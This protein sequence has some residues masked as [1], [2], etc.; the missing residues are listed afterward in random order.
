[1]NSDNQQV[2][3]CEGGE[4][5]VYCD[6]CDSLCRELY[7]RNLLKSKTQTIIIRKRQEL[8]KSFQKISLI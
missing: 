2:F 6:V 8:N 7:Y 3:Y 5:R 4:D 1:M